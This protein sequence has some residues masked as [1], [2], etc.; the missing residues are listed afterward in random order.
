MSQMPPALLNLGQGMPGGR[1][2]ELKFLVSE[3]VFEAAQK[4]EVFG[5]A[6]PQ[7]AQK[8]HSV[9]YDT[10]DG[11]LHRHK[12]VLRM[13]HQPGCYVMAFKWQD[14]ACV[15]PFERGEVEVEMAEPKLDP[16][17][18]GEEIATIIAKLTEG[19]ELHPV[20]ATEITRLTRWVLWGASA[21]EVAFDAGFI[22]AGKWREPVREIELE[23]KSGEPEALFQLGNALC[24]TF[25]VQPG[26]QS[27]SERAAALHRARNAVAPA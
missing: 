14:P 22:V 26:L 15:N 1:E 21:I 3:A 19:R 9:Y 6:P 27:K 17:L 10:D 8:L 25:E 11:V 4:W 7:P 12:M 24:S 13:R 18:L 16:S 20:Y 5:D 2:I 23:L